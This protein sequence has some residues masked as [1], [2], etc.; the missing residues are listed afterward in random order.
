MKDVREEDKAVLR[1]G[2]VKTT[3]TF[4]LFSLLFSLLALVRGGDCSF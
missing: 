4:C 2:V 1:R 3:A